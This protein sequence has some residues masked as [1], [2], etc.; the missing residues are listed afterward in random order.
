MR[1]NIENI[2]NLG[3][4]PFHIGVFDRP[5][6]P[7]GF[8]D[9]CDFKIGIEADLGLVVQAP[10]NRTQT[11]LKRAYQTG[12]ILG[13]PMRGNGLGAKYVEDI[14]SFIK[15]SAGYLKG[16][17]ILEIGC[18]KG[19]LLERL[20][21]LNAKVAGIEPGLNRRT[22][23]DIKNL[24]IDDFYPS[25]KLSG[26]FDIIIHYGVLE[27]VEDPGFFLSSHREN[28]KANGIIIFSV[29]DCSG[30]LERGDISILF[31]EHRSF[32]DIHSLRSLLQSINFKIINLRKGAAADAI[33]V[34]CSPNSGKPAY[35]EGRKQIKNIGQRFN[36]SIGKVKSWFREYCRKG[37]RMGVYCPGRFINYLYK[38]TKY[39]NMRFFDDEASFYGKFFPPFNI[40]IESFE[41]LILN[42]V[43]KMII[44]STFFEDDIVKKIKTAGILNPKNVFL[45]KDI[46][47]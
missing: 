46:I 2:C 4:L 17:D 42:P 11:L 32:F 7:L 5:S 8:P 16:K 33:Y 24:I 39:E 1:S 41:D 25:D 40:R 14:L 20:K 22:K 10:S 26:R 12:S 13:V 35:N 3:K 44:A 34:A 28:L 43:D 9:V 19:V 37:E 27:H 30:Y 6:N 36:Y 29:P 18:G 23:S 15:R 38:L 21:S 31:H 45:L 47:L